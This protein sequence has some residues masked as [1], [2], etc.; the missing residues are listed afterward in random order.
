[1]ILSLMLLIVVGMTGIL[2]CPDASVERGL[3]NFFLAWAGL[4]PLSYD[5]SL[6]Q[7]WDD[8]HAPQC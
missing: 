5:F 2:P 3:V 4:E 1:M 7:S 6:L 8:R